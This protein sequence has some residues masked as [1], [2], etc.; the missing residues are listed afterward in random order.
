MSARTGSSGADEITIEAC[1]AGEWIVEF[2]GGERSLHVYRLGSSDWLVSEVGR[3][4][5]GRGATLEDA[6]VA[7]GRDQFPRWLPVLDVI[8]RFA[9]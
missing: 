7:L 1:A 6:L 3:P 8:D 2:R 4:S 9:G 5:E